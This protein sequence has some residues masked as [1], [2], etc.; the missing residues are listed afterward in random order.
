MTNDDFSCKVNLAGISIS[1]F[2]GAFSLYLH[3]SILPV[4]Y[5]VFAFCVIIAHAKFFCTK[6]VYYG[7]DCY[8]HGAKLAKRYFER[9]GPGSAD[10]DAMVLSLWLL[11]AM[12]PVP[13]LL[14]YQDFIMSGIYLS[15]AFFA[16]YVHNNTACTVC[17]NTRCGLNPRSKFKGGI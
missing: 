12:L 1:L 4:L 16:F 3:N 11:L 7:K 13:F 17:D 8:I 14:Y 6:C 5:I 15:S 9:S 10:D 2:L